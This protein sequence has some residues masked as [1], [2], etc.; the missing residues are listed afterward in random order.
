MSKAA[1]GEKMEKSLLAGAFV[2]EGA[3]KANFERAGIN[4]DTGFG[5]G[6]IYSANRSESGYGDISIPGERA[7]HLLPEEKPG[8]LE[9]IVAAAADY[10]VYLEMGTSRMPARPFIRPALDENAEKVGQA[11]GENLRRLVFGG[12]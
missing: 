12:G 1:R 9:A 4:V 7:G 5:R 11:G 6:S 10:D 8:A 3:A 2:L